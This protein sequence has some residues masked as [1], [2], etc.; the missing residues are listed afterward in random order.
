MQ[1]SNTED[2]IEIDLKEI[3]GILWHRLV[4]IV[5]CGIVFGI[6]GFA[7]SN[8]VITPLYESTTKVYIL[9]KDDNSTVTY[10]DVQ[11]GTQLT[12]DYVELIKSRHVLEQVSD[13]LELEDTYAGLN[14]RVEVTTPSGTR[15]IAISVIDENPELAQ[16]I[17]NEIREVASEHIK[18][19]MD[20]QAV[21]IAEEA[22][23]PSEPVSPSVSKWT[24][25]GAFLGVFLICA[26]IILRYLLDDTIKT[27]DDIEKYLELS[28]LALIPKFSEDD[29]TA[30]TPIKSPVRTATKVPEKNKTHK[31]KKTGTSNIDPSNRMLKFYNSIAEL[32]DDS[33]YIKIDSASE[34]SSFHVDEAEGM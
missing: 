34:T 4:L 24:A 2:L 6:A 20:I 32:E 3:I 8:F 13:T 10:S 23:L 15:I 18:N 29:R 14:D 28:T 16:Q 11:L 17:A 9:N 7:I 33:E 26:V 31:A 5:L 19:V 1:N 21:N 27:A 12:K 25:I 22:N 30:K